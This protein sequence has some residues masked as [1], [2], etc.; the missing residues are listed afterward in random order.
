MHPR[1]NGMLFVA[2]CIQG[3]MLSLTSSGTPRSSPR[4]NHVILIDFIVKLYIL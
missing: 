3:A 4:I 2:V 1:Y